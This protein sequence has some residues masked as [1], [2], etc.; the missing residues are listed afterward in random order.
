MHGIIKI[1]EYRIQGIVG[2]YPH[3]RETA[4]ELLVDIEMKVDF[5][6]AVLTDA[7][8]DTVNYEEIGMI[9][10]NLIREREYKLLETFAFEALNAILDDYIQIS[11]A[12]IRVCKPRALPLAKHVVIELQKAR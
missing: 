12:Q 10:R 3:E 7:I 8:V 1:V 6:E 11:W 4:Q 5:S 9:C 2:V